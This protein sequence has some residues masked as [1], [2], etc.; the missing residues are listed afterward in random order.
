MLTYEHLSFWEKRTYL[1]QLDAVIIGSGIVGMA[2]AIHLK[3]A[4]PH[5]K[6]L[7]LER[8]YLPTG[9]ST[10]NAGFACFGSPSELQ[11]DLNNLP[12]QTV[13]DTLAMRYEGLQK[14]FELVPKRC[15]GYERCGS[16]DLMHEP[17]DSDFIAYLNQH[18]ARITGQ[19]QVYQAD[20]LKIRRS[21]IQGFTTAYK[22]R[23]EGSL[24][25]D[26]LIQSLHQLCIQRGIH[27]LFGTEVLSLEIGNSSNRVITAFGSIESERIALCTNALARKFFPLEVEPARAQVLVT[28]PL[29]DLKINGT[30]H[31]DAGYYY[32]RNVH[33]RV[34]FGGGRNTA[35]EAE[36]T[37]SMHPTDGL[38]NHLESI[39]RTNI[40][41]NQTFSIAYRWAGTM[42]VGPT[43][44][45]I[46]K[47]V[48]PGVAVGVRMGGM[49]VAMGAL[50]GE[51]LSKLM[52]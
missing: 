34:L 50:V 28:S 47:T 27:F 20:S 40:L 12:E 17:L 30:F 6:I 25:T 21:G 35:F 22:N 48:A 32:F 26:L 19:T 36:N 10:K 18:V 23:S 14:L 31:F 5:L 9:A 29:P 16:W 3:K 52:Q 44:S 41:P 51:K 38:Q 49:G 11:D 2:C 43:K 4:K 24:H 39:L 13:W 15:I 1:E 42:G 46:V 8:G 7:L 33:D 45:P 37:A